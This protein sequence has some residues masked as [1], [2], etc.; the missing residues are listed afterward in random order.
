MTLPC[1]APPDA[2]AT[3]AGRC[4]TIMVYMAADNDLEAQALADLAEIKTV[5]STPQVTIVAQLDRAQPGQP[6]RRYYLTRLRTLEAIRRPPGET[7][8]GDAGDLARRTGR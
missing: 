2:K 5:G 8:S 1:A 4:W 7:N 6:T 3:F